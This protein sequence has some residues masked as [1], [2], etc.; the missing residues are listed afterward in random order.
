MEYENFQLEIDFAIEEIEDIEIR[1]ILQYKYI[2]KWTDAK[3]GKELGY[4]RSTI[5]KKIN[6]FFE[7]Q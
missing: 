7:N 5:T 3:I 1:Q 4:D 2:E 6:N